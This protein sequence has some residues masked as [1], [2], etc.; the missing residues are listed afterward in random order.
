M[1]DFSYYV[2][3]T[4]F[5]THFSLVCKLLEDR[6]NAAFIFVFP[7]LTLTKYIIGP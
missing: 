4:W 1:E 3:I 5:H 2:V 7:E 6:D